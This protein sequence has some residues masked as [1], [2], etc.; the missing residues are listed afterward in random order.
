MTPASTGA[1][2]K[3]PAHEYR[4]VLVGE[5]LHSK[6]HDGNDEDYGYKPQLFS[7]FGD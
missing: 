3:R 5:A 4:L 6:P 1:I 2:L 7:V